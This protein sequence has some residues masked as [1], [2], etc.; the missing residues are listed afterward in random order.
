[1][2]EIDKDTIMPVCEGD[3]LYTHKLSSNGL[4]LILRCQSRWVWR[5]EALS[6]LAPPVGHACFLYNNEGWHVRRGIG[7]KVVGD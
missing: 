1:M 4:T 5:S 6:Q 3:D 2:R 7:R